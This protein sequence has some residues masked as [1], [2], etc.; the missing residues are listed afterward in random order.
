MIF[1]LNI[2]KLISQHI[3]LI[4][5]GVPVLHLIPVPFPEVWHKIGD[6]GDN[7]DDPTVTKLNQILRIFV[8]QFLKLNPECLRVLKTKGPAVSTFRGLN[9]SQ[10]NPQPSRHRIAKNKILK[11][12]EEKPFNSSQLKHSKSENS[13]SSKNK[14]LE[15]RSAKPLTPTQNQQAK[16]GH[17]IHNQNQILSEGPSKALKKFDPKQ[18][19]TSLLR[20][21]NL[22]QNQVLRQKRKSSYLLIKIAP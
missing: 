10:L 3:F 13:I 9:P 5:L 14:I 2:F 7:V 12:V 22:N 1:G 11:R 8:A 21:S 18:T 15:T 6:N 19:L 4:H 17:P 16:S 20:N